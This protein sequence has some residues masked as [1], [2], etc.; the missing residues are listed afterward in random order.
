MR[1]IYSRARR[2]SMTGHSLQLTAW[3]ALLAA[4]SLALAEEAKTKAPPPDAEFLE[5]LGSVDSEDGKWTEY[6][7]K[8]D[9]KAGTGNKE[10]VEARGADTPAQQPKKTQVEKH[11]Q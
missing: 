7:A 1:I 4:S 9:V 6:L 11:E 5:C 2:F 3:C 8:T 10:R